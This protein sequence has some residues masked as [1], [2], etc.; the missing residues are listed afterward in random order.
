MTYSSQM[1]P[2]ALPKVTGAPQ[3]H[4]WVNV[5]E[6]LLYPALDPTQPDT[7][8]YGLYRRGPTGSFEHRCDIVMVI[9]QMREGDQRG[10][11]TLLG[12]AGPRCKPGSPDSGRR[13]D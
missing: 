11:V 4:K 6:I 8:R 9:L 3:L 7:E 10:K 12:N 2:K 1:V 5:M 13:G